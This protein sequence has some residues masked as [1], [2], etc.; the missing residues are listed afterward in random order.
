[1]IG[2]YV[3][4]RLLFNLWPENNQFNSY[5]RNART[6]ILAIAAWT[7]ELPGPHGRPIDRL[8]IG[9]YHLGGIGQPA[10]TSPGRVDILA[11]VKLA[12]GNDQQTQAR[13]LES[14]WTRPEMPNGVRRRS[15][16]RRLCAKV[17]PESDDGGD[18][19]IGVATLVCFKPG[20][21]SM[22]IATGE[23]DEHGIKASGFE[24]I[25]T[26]ERTRELRI[27]LQSSTPRPPKPRRRC[28]SSTTSSGKEG[29][30][31]NAIHRFKGECQ[32]IAI[33]SS[34]GRGTINCGLQLDRG[35]GSRR[36]ARV[37]AEFSGHSYPL[38]SR[39]L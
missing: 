20:P 10:P 38:T 15:G 29:T 21:I 30:M 33:R 6:D 27:G 2:I 14:R 17:S 3:I 35:N 5:F 1:M 4:R 25:R 19:S 8:T 7:V 31:M 11:I 26:R 37:L 16:S 22:S 18:E 23:E 13:F 28:T 24:A 32:L 9:V 36:E 39:R 34:P 12:D